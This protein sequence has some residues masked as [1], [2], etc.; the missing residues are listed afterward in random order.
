MQNQPGHR[1][2]RM[3]ADRI[4]DVDS[5]SLDSFPAS[6]PPKWSG[7]RIGPPVDS[8]LPDE[9]AEKKVAVAAMRP[10]DVSAAQRPSR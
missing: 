8:E 3:A 9:A 10:I 7:L 2:G 6:D 1:T 4:D 5:A